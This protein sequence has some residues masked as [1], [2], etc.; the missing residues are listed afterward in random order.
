MSRELYFCVFQIY[1]H[2]QKC[3]SRYTHIYMY[4]CN[5]QIHTSAQTFTWIYA[6]VPPPLPLSAVPQN[7]HDLRTPAPLSLV[8]LLSLPFIYFHCFSGGLKKF[9]STGNILKYFGMGSILKISRLWIVV[10]L[11]V[12]DY[13]V[14][15]IHNI[16]SKI[17]P[18]GKL[19][20]M[21]NA[22]FKCLSSKTVSS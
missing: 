7:F 3:I 18:P 4:M 20:W 5:L 13:I 22:V 19:G 12:I 9:K 2:I 6:K 11:I 10:S 17:Y 15:R 8:F 14:I 16:P 1:T 21:C